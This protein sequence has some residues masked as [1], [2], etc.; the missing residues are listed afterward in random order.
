MSTVRRAYFYAVSLVTLVVSS[1]G[2][3]IL[4]RLL[5][6]LLFSRTTISVTPGFFRDQ[7]SLGLAMV[8]IAGPIWF[9][10]WR[11][12]QRHACCDSGEAGAALRKLH[13]CLVLTASSLTALMTGVGVLHWLLGGLSATEFQAGTLA[14]FIVSLGVWYH[15]W[16]VDLADG[17]PCSRGKTLQR[18][19]W[20]TVSAWALVLFA[21]GVINALGIMLQTSGVWGGESIVQGPLWSAD[22]RTRVASL[23]LGLLWWCFQWL[24]TARRDIGSV[25][26]Q[27][28]LYLF[29]ILSGAIA[30]LVSLSIT[31][32]QSL[33]FGLGSRGSSGEPYFQFLSW[34]LPAMVVGLAVWVYHWQKVKEEAMANEGRRSSARRV[35]YYLLSGV[36]LG[37]ALA[38]LV[39]LVG[40]LL[41]LLLGALDPSQVMATTPGWR[42]DPLA[43]FAVLM[44]VGSAIWLYHWLGMQREATEKDVTERGARSRR[45]YLY[46]FLCLGIVALVASLVNIV[47]R[48][49]AGGL[50]G[51]PLLSVLQDTKWS[52]QVFL[53]AAPTLAYHWRVLREDHGVG[54][55]KATAEKVVVAVIDDSSRLALVPR[56]QTALGTRIRVLSI[57]G[58]KAGPSLVLSDE[59]LRLLA[60]D[61]LASPHER[62]LLLVHGTE[63]ELYPYREA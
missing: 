4:L 51:T 63:V 17:E 6:D 37:A 20:Y 47:Y 58:E 35:Y 16:R 10:H 12:A 24:W 29:A 27:V 3:G 38:G 11:V 25:L 62:L 26:R 34:T 31:L 40:L 5:L 50:Q 57:Q 61:V 19:Y 23:L 14:A 18:W 45:V 59:E 54:A 42:R 13:L 43:L 8:V 32:F 52:L 1:W 15:H 48:L 9:I 28:Y 7:L 56:L 2:I 46:T 49:L 39:V 36:G 53:V 21:S 55:E 30:T 44:L 41:D 60:R 33:K 22:V